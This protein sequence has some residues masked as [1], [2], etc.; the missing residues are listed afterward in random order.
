MTK[1]LRY[2]WVAKTVQE[3]FRFKVKTHLMN[4]TNDASYFKAHIPP[5]P[6]LRRVEFASPN[7]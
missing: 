2:K 4:L 6:G 5:K 3:G 7:A 1:V